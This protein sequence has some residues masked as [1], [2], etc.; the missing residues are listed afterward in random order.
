VSSAPDCRKIIAH[1]GEV[2]LVPPAC[3]FKG[4]YEV[5]M[6][7]EHWYNDSSRGR[8]RYSEK[9][10]AHCHFVHPKSHISWR[11]IEPIC[12]LT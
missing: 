11:G 6:I 4:Q 9:N 2:I 3:H 1:F 10:L 5:D 12:L 7:M 8:L